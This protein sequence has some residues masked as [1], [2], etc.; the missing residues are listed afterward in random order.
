MFITVHIVFITVH[1]VFITVH[2]VFITVHI[3][4]ST[5]KN[6]NKN[7]FRFTEIQEES[8]SQ[9]IN[10]LPNKNSYGFDGISSKLFKLIEPDIMKPLT[11]L[12]NQVLNTGQYPDKKVA[13]VITI[14]KKKLS[15]IIHKL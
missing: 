9:I 5:F 8:V 1:I 4:F 12:I 2:I 11:L 10:N 14:F 15:H 7:G 13:K 6:K 3:M